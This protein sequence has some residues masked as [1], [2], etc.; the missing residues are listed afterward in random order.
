MDGEVTRAEYIPRNTSIMEFPDISP[1]APAGSHFPAGMQMYNQHYLMPPHSHH[2]R[3]RL[4]GGPVGFGNHQLQSTEDMKPILQSHSQTTHFERASQ[5]SQRS[6]LSSASGVDYPME[7]MDHSP[8][9]SAMAT[10]VDAPAQTESDDESEEDSKGSVGSSSPNGSQSLQKRDPDHLKDLKPA[11]QLAYLKSFSKEMLQQA[12]ESQSQN[13]DDPADPS[14]SNPKP[15]TACS[16]C[17]KTFSRPCEL[18]KHNKRHE[19]PYGCTWYQCN[20]TF[21]SKNDWKRHETNQHGQIETWHCPHDC[22][23]VF[24]SRES[25]NIHLQKHHKITDSALLERNLEESRQGSHCTN[26]F[27]CGFCNKLQTTTPSDSVN[28]SNQRFDHIDDHFMGRHGWKKLR[29]EE[30]QHMEEQTDDND[31]SISKKT[32]LSEADGDGGRKNK[33]QRAN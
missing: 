27:W 1:P 16:T 22:R 19:K 13:V 11:D 17:E 4:S 23:K 29:I 31:R 2:N 14:H 5:E 15:N 9:Q 30:W 33:R 7:A 26:S 20:R 25:F 32:H 3:H 24:N 8:R 21:G 10:A 28:V 18:R 6:V 12:L